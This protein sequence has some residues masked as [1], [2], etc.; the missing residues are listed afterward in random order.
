VLFGTLFSGVANI[1]GFDNDS[2]IAYMLPSIII[3]NALFI[4]I[5]LGLG[6][7]SDLQSG[8][9]QR[10]LVVPIGRLSIVFSDLLYLSILQFIQT[11]I[12]IFI[13]LLMGV[14][15]SFGIWGLLLY[16]FV[17]IVFAM[18]VGSLSISTALISKKHEAMINVMQ[19]CS[20]PMMFLSSAF[21]THNL[22]PKWIRWL[23]IINP[24]DWTIS[25]ERTV[26]NG[27]GFLSWGPYAI[28]LLMFVGA[29]IGLCI[30]SFNRYRHSI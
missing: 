27:Y 23:T 1:S 19:F 12:L 26:I 2:Y 20:M 11:I 25:L 16:T 3:M 5:Y 29:S 30:Y 6:T 9:L 14:K 17:P 13:S 22:M 28:V 18:S 10:F 21:M 24:V 7:I 15:L 8:V 4:G